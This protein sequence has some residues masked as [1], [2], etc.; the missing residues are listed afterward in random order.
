MR[1]GRNNWRVITNGRGTLL[2][3]KKKDTTRLRPLLFPSFLR[4][5][6]LKQAKNS[7]PEYI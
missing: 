3:K 2:K 6:L 5:E 1:K 4:S 7:S